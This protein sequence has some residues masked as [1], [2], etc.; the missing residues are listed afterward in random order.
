MRKLKGDP[1]RDLVTMSP[2]LTGAIER[3]GK[4]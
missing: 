4:R 1:L 2:D 3:L